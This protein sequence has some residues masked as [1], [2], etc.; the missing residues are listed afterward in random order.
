MEKL[1]NPELKEFLLQL[2]L[3]FSGSRSILIKRLRTAL[4]ESIYNINTKELKYILRTLNLPTYGNKDILINQLEK[5][6]YK[7]S[8]LLKL[9]SGVQDTDREVLLHLDDNVLYI[10][11]EVNKYAYNLCNGSFWN[12]RIKQ[13]YEGANLQKYKGNATYKTIYKELREKDLEHILYYAANNGYLPIIEYIIKVGTH[14]ITI[15]F[16]RQ[17]TLALNKASKNGHLE[18]VK[19]LIEQGA[20]INDGYN[21][22]LELAARNGHLPIVKF[23]VEHGADIHRDSELALT[24]AVTEGYF[25]VVKYLVEH[26]A[27]IER[28][29]S[30]RL[31]IVV[32]I[33]FS[34]Y[35]IAKYLT[36]QLHNINIQN[37]KEF[38]DAVKTK[39]YIGLHLYLNK[40]GYL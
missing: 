24:Y 1:T 21:S 27:Y 7:E 22:A 18:V 30:D 10:I 14:H 15:E 32:A 40:K 9:F 31:A 17:L 12:T 35:N 26:G 28:P 3:S 25:D 34:H 23:L 33:N 6:L 36:E 13:K 16:I 4:I 39:G 38:I 5:E 11:C 2:G 8:T 19:Y 29:G 20:I 37:E